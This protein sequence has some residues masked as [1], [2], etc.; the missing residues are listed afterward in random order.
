M[1]TYG[2]LSV[3][4][5]FSAFVGIALIGLEMVNFFSILLTILGFVFSVFFFFILCLTNNN[6][7]LKYYFLGK[8]FQEQ[9]KVAL[10]QA[11]CMDSRNFKY[12]ISE[13]KDMYR[14]FGQLQVIKFDPYSLFKREVNDFS[15]E[16]SNDQMKLNFIV[17]KLFVGS[18][19]DGGIN[20]LL[21]AIADTPFTKKE[22][23]KICS[24][25]GIMSSRLLD[26]LD[27]ELKYL[28]F[29][30]RYKKVPNKIEF[31]SLVDMLS[32]NSYKLYFFEAELINILDY[33]AGIISKKQFN[34]IANFSKY[35]YSA[36]GH[37]RG[38]VKSRKN[39]YIAVIEN[40]KQGDWE[41]YENSKP[42]AT[43]SSALNEIKSTIKNYIKY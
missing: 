17:F 6:Y 2:F 42:F 12:L 43:R 32:Y 37:T 10:Q 11:P 36:D 40:L 25:S 8:K 5:F 21:M 7:K 4:C 30:R 35:L 38:Y 16:I 33:L 41:V 15:Y 14:Q 28:R 26:Y 29:V 34:K 20:N 13:Y 18:I 22:I 1:I 27:N 31:R 9:L 24:K 3:A 19:S 39:N 23:M